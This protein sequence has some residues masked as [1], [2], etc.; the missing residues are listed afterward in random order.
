MTKSEVKSSVSPAASSS[1]SAQ[2][3]PWL[4]AVTSS[5]P[6]ASGWSL[7]LEIHPHPGQSKERTPWWMVLEHRV[8]EQLLVN[9][10]RSPGCQRAQCCA[11]GVWSSPL[12]HSAEPQVNIPILK[13][14]LSPLPLQKQDWHLATQTW[15]KS[16]ELW[17]F[18]VSEIWICSKTENQSSPH[19][20]TVLVLLACL[21]NTF[22]NHF[23][24]SKLC[25]TNHSNWIPAS[26]ITS[27]E[28]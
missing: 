2:P 12:P 19:T 13:G 25:L 14:L 11:W 17:S 20:H 10:Q 18:S 6:E 24:F 16:E 22:I 9:G 3:R 15:T 1:S 23:L 8:P 26:E 27:S 28:R 5:S 7:P 4:S 21:H